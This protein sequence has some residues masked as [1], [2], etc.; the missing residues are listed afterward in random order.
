VPSGSHARVIADLDHVF[1]V[2]L[3]VWSESVARDWMS[4]PNAHLDGARPIDVVR[5]RGSGEVVDALR[6]EAAGAYA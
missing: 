3:Q 4:A 6:A 2:A 5:A 1:A